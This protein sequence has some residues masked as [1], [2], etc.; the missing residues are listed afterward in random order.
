MYKMKSFCGKAIAGGLMMT[1]LLTVVWGLYA[2]PAHAADEYDTLR[3]KWQ[4]TLNGGTS[5]SPSDPDFANR[6]DSIT[7]EANRYWG[8]MDKSAGR[9]YLWSD[10]SGTGGSADL[11]SDY[12]RLRAMAI[13]NTTYGSPLNGDSVLR[14]DIIGALDWMYANHYSETTTSSGNWWDWQIGVPLALGDTV[15]LM[16]DWLTP[17]Q[18]TNYMNAVDHFTPAVTMTGANRVWQA[19]V[20]GVRGVLVKDGAKIGAARDGLSAVFSYVASSNGYYRDGSF[21]EHNKYSYTGGYGISLLNNM[22]NLMY[23]LEG[24]TWTVT[25]SNKGNVFQWVYDSYQPLVYKGAMMDMSRGREISRNYTQD[26]DAGH[27][28]MQGIL[29]LSQFAPAADAAAYKQMIKAWIQA[30][31]FSS[32]YTNAPVN[33]IALAKAIMNDSS[34]APASELVKYQQFSGMDRA[35]V[36]RPGYGFGV[37]MYSNRIGSY[38]PING[39]NLKGWYTGFGM[40]YLYN[41]DLSQ[42]S[43]GFWPTVDAARLPGT[44]VVSQTPIASQQSPNNWVGGADMDG[45]YGVS[46]MDLSAS[47]SATSSTLS[48]KKSWFMFDDEIVALGAGITSNYGNAVETIVEN[49]KLGS[50]GSNALTV[51]GTAQP[52]TLGWSQTLSGVNWAHLAGNVA[53]SDIGYYFPQPVTLQAVREARTGNWQQVNGRATTPGDAITN[54]YVTMWMNHGVDPTN[55]SYQY[56]LLPN[57][58]ASQVS[59]YASNP[60]IT[61]LENSTEAQAV[62]E[63][64]LGIV[65]ANFWND[66][67]KTVDLITAD[68]KAS[69]MTKE[70]ASDIEVS[71]SDPTK[72]NAGVINI[73]LNRSAG[74]TLSS[75]PE[76]TVTQLSPT[77]KFTVNVSGA[78]GKAFKVKFGLGSSAAS[79]IVD[80][81]DAS[82]VVKTGTWTTSSTET[83]RYGAN[84]LSDGNAGKGT[85]TVTFTPNLSAA[86]TYHVYM[87]YPDHTNRATNVPVDISS[88]GGTSTVTVNEQT[89]GG[90]WN[91]LGTYSFAAGT[92][93][94]V[95]IRTDGTNGYVVADA[96]KF[97]LVPAP[98]PII[99]D[100]GDSSGVA[101]VGTWTSSTAQSD[102]YGTNYIHDGNSGKGTK[103][104]TF[105]PNVTTAGDYKVYVYWSAYPNRATNVPVDIQSSSG[106][107]TVTVNEQQNGGQWNLLGTYPF[108]AGTAGTVTIRN[109]S[110]NGYVVAD[111]VKLEW[112]P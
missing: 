18:L 53:G 112:A 69:V 5:Y 48:A 101:K 93:G 58:I 91:L 98:S 86:G 16:Y 40:T 105:T 60:D 95:T 107:A 84:Y 43:N 21:V 54:N 56:V 24:S 49:R 111:A 35:L 88:T 100:N 71:V 19:A 79:V 14:G 47:T 31:T 99:V 1:L 55:G 87:M 44:T 83:D 25:N 41:S 23:L 4:V 7:T 30:D 11:T 22:A 78:R 17:T 12:T 104:V 57:K 70:T 67:V 109:D 3:A 15:A 102:Y 90:V 106:T 28:V 82:G 74:S 76:I 29:R 34:I 75:D 103:S 33:M 6:I 73:E 81:A 97:E 37:S 9:T 46:G 59:S 26:H 50:S 42:Y 39:E 13:A 68:K 66:A 8:D 64:N 96:V 62:K 92:N 108:A 85:K 51:N 89:Y 20:V 110:T 72:S 27:L 80:N 77:I 65:A 32:F 63:K 2:P 52:T 45:T 94:A 61:V 36:L 38:E 10:L